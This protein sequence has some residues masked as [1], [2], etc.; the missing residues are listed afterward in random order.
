[1]LDFPKEKGAWHEVDKL[2]LL[3]R[4]NESA[5]PVR[6]RFNSLAEQYLKNDFGADAVRPKTE[7]TPLTTRQIVR[8]Y[9]VPRWE[10]EIAGPSQRRC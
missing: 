5:C 8:A 7:R 9:L 1:V 6:I 3:V 4:I 2:G 10:R